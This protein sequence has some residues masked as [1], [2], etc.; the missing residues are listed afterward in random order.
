MSLAMKFSAQVMY[1][2]E[3]GG[4]DPA[5][6][7][8]EKISEGSM[9]YLRNLVYANNLNA[10]EVIATNPKTDNDATRLIFFAMLVSAICNLLKHSDNASPIVVRGLSGKRLELLNVPKGCTTSLILN[11]KG[12]RGI[13]AENKQFVKPVKLRSEL[14]SSKF[15]GT[16]ESLEGYLSRFADNTP[17]RGNVEMFLEKDANIYVTRFPCPEVLLEGW[18]T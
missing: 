18:A 14:S 4:R 16:Q 7:S 2:V 3:A 9:R 17:T 10:V 15:G 6:I 13:L 1:L 5:T 8:L 11:Q 12:L